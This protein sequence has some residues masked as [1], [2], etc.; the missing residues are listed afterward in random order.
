MLVSIPVDEPIG[1]KV[2]KRVSY[3]G[4]VGYVELGA[5]VR[6]CLY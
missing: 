3:F 4:V 6:S 1:E 2:E 5:G